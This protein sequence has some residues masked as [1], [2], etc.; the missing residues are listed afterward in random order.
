M[1]SA[2]ILR[3]CV[4]LVAVVFVLHQSISSLYKPVTTETAIFYGGTE[5][6]DIAALIVRNE[7][8][9]TD[10][11]K[12]ALHFMVEDGNR[13]AKDGVIAQVYDSESASIT[14]NQIDNLNKRIEDIENI[15]AYNNLDATDLETVNEKLNNAV[16]DLVIKC[17]SG[18]YSQI[19]ES[20]QEL[21]SV[22][23]RKQMLIGATTDFTPQLTELKQQVTQLEAS[24][25]DIKDKITADISGYFVSNIDGYE[26][27]VDLS[28]LSKIT[29]ESFEKIEPKDNSKNVIGKIVSDY[30]W[31]VIA[32]ISINDSLTYKEGDT[33]KISTSLK[34]APN[35]TATVKHINV[36]DVG[37]NA[38]IV[39]A[40]NQMSSEIATIRTAPMTLVKTEYSGLKVPRRAL[41]VS[42]SKTGVYVINSM[43]VKFVPVN[44][45][46][47]N[48]DY[49][50]CEQLASDDNVLRLYDEVI[51]KGRNLYDG[52]II[53]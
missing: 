47:S 40:C 8:I 17:A 18:K 19:E 35:L 25:P 45:V 21:Y 20:K 36:S 52:K 12:G 9:V 44:V 14:V 29:P 16:N 50:I 38:I 1:N 53:S 22:I 24:L 51:V 23:N 42:D 7:T 48:D 30:E 15:I 31:Y 41:R 46:F 4:I 33:V 2:K 37:E 27:S 39:L 5:G 43:Q 28:S 32:Q 26:K 34:T 49:I 11:A 10:D 13:V 6:V 3:A